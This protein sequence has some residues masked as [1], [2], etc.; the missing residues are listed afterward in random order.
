MRQIRLYTDQAL[1]PGQALNLASGP[2]H[3][4]VKVLRARAGDKVTLFDGSGMD[5]PCTILTIDRNRVSLSVGKGAPGTQGSPLNCHLGLCLSK[6]DRFDWAVQKATELGVQAITPL[7]SERVEVKLPQERVP[8]RLRHW[9]QIVA[10]ACEQSG[11]SLLPKIH[12]PLQL[13]VWVARQAAD[14]KAVLHHHEAG[15]LPDRRPDSIAL[16]VGPEGGLGP[17]DMKSAKSAGFQNLNLGPRV[18]RT[19]TAPL[20]ALSVLGAKWG[21]IL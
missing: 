21:D 11:R 1:Q 2:A 18:L 10:S 9:G 8:N 4:L 13:N 20:V 19:E 6:G 17:E 3:H 12:E 15:G 7:F 5:Y 14:F 16:L